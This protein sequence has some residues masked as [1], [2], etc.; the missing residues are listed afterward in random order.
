[1]H[2]WQFQASHTQP[3]IQSHMLDYKVT[4]TFWAWE[5]DMP[6]IG[7]PPMPHAHPTMILTSRSLSHFTNL[8]ISYGSTRNDLYLNHIQSKDDRRGKNHI[9]RPWPG[10]VMGYL[11]HFNEKDWGVVFQQ[12]T[13][14]ELSLGRIHRVFQIARN[15]AHLCEA[16]PHEYGQACTQKMGSP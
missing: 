9:D 2:D 3:W 11:N 10:S 8:S 15:V 16:L 4:S 14:K 7:L 13:I 12:P 1:M 5:V 6:S